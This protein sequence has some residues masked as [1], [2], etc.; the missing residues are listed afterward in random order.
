M[1]SFFDVSQR[2]TDA[3]RSPE[4]RRV[5]MRTWW[6][7][8][9]GERT[10]RF[11]IIN[12]AF[13]NVLY[14]DY[15]QTVLSHPLKDDG[16]LVTAGSTSD[17]TWKSVLFF[18]QSE[19]RIEEYRLGTNDP[20]GVERELSGAANAVVGKWFENDED[21]ELTGRTYVGGKDMDGDSRLETVLFYVSSKANWRDASRVLDNEFGA[22][23]IMQLDGGDSSFLQCR[24]GKYVSTGR[25][26]PHVFVVFEAP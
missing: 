6:N 16:R 5:N 23:T 10:E 13:F 12:G 26:V 22:W 14:L 2:L 9:T 25:S 11:C 18:D 20:R 7:E 3:N 1:E 24:S 4:F 21:A 19:V 15:W 17:R 8:Y